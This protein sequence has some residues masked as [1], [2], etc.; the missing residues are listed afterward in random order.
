[1][2]KMTVVAAILVWGLFFTG[3]GEKEFYSVSI[4]NNTS[5]GKTVSYDYNDISDTLAYEKTNYYQVKAYT[6][7]PANVR[8]QDG[9]ASI[10]MINWQGEKFTFENA[11]SFDLHVANCLPVDITIKADN[12]I[13]NGETNPGPGPEL[14]IDAGDKNTKGKIYTSKPKF[15]ADN[16]NY[17]VV[18]EWNIVDDDNEKT[19][20]VIIR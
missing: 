13:D 6:Q 18:F 17:P 15:T 8:D 2:K 1:M 16:T 3:C 12:Y 20:Y 4:I 19:M 10:T 14:K 9:I 7:P 11:V 5:V